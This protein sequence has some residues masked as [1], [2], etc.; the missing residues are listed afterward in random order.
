ME[1]S[2]VHDITRVIQLA[3]APAFLLTAVGSLLNVF[4]NRLARIVDRYRVTSRASSALPGAE[5]ALL[6][7]DE[8]AVL[9]RRASLVRW[10][11]TFAT[12]AALLVSL[13]IA[14]AFLGFILQVNFS[15]P[16]AI[17]FVTA[18][19]LLTVALFFFLREVTVAI[20]S[21]RALAPRGA[22]RPPGPDERPGG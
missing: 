13:V 8:R 4:A 6:P 2:H 14:F 17:M 18:M 12:G 1:E 21:V 15:R 20:G 16:V 10:S 5:P 11:I 7:G 9:E 19:A 3:L 22:R